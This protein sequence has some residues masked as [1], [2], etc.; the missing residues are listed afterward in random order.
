[1][2]ISFFIIIS[3][4][5]KKGRLRKSI[6]SFFFYFILYCYHAIFSFASNPIFFSVFEKLLLKKYKFLIDVKKESRIYK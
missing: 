5:Y 4:D 6:C 2:K 3:S 1:M